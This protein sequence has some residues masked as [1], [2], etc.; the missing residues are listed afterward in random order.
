MI[1]KPSESTVVLTLRATLLLALVAMLVH[2]LFFATYQVAGSTMWPTL[3]DGDRI[4]VL[5]AFPTEPR[6][7]DVVIVEVDGEILVKRLA[8]IPGDRIAMMLGNRSATLELVFAAARIGAISLPI[9]TRLSPREVGFLLND[10][11]PMALVYESPVREIALK[12][13]QAIESPPRARLEVGGEP[14]AYERELSLHDPAP[15]IHPVHPDD[16]MMLMYKR[17]G[18]VLSPSL[19]NCPRDS[20]IKTS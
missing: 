1:R 18:R 15:D 20:S 11:R 9:N 5:E 7:G 14:D 8:A 3:G 4:L 6:V 13:C 19:F 2:G 10:C 16:P 17:A 12:A